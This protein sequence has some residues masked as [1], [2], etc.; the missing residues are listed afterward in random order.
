MTKD[1]GAEESQEAYGDELQSGHRMPGRLRVEGAPGELL[2]QTLLREGA[3][4]ATCS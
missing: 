2:L 1:E 4:G 3:A